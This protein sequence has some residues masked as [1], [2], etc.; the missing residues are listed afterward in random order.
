MKPSSSSSFSN[1]ADMADKKPTSRDIAKRFFQRK[2]HK[3]VI[4]ASDGT[5][6]EF[7]HRQDEDRARAYARKHS[8][9]ID[10]IYRNS[11]SKKDL[12]VSVSNEKQPTK[13]KTKKS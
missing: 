2:D 5:V 8:L 7:K 11:F 10:Y 12:E 4:I 9:S 13:G 6:F 3:K 1:L